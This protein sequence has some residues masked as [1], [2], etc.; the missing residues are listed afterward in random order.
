[1]LSKRLDDH[2]GQ[3]ARRQFLGTAA[4]VGAA[5]AGVSALDPAEALGF[6][7]KELEEKLHEVGTVNGLGVGSGALTEFSKQ[8]EKA[9]GEAAG[10]T[11]IGFGVLTKQLK[12]TAKGFTMGNTGVGTEA[13]HANESGVHNTAIGNSALRAVTG[14]GTT[15]EEEQAGVEET[16]TGYAGGF[17][18]AVGIGCMESLK[19][20]YHNTGMG[21]NCMG[22]LTGSNNTAFGANT[23][24][25][26][27]FAAKDTAI[28]I[29]AMEHAW[30]AQNGTAGGNNALESSRGGS[31]NTAWG[32]EALRYL[33][34]GNNNT[35][36]GGGAM[37][38]VAGV[39][40]AMK[41]GTTFNS[42]TPT[43]VEVE[44]ESITYEGK[45]LTLPTG[46]FEAYLTQANGNSVRIKVTKRTGKIL[47]GVTVTQGEDIVL[48]SGVFK[49]EETLVWE[50]RTVC[51]ENTVIGSDALAALESG[52]RN[53]AVGRYSLVNQ[54]TG[55]GNTA[56]GHASGFSNETAGGNTIVG[57][58]G[59]FANKSGGN[60]TCI[61]NEAGKDNEGSENIFLGAQAGLKE[62]GSKKLYIASSETTEPLI[63]GEFPNGELAFNTSKIALYKGVTPVTRHATIAE[64]TPSSATAKEAAERINEIVKAIKAIGII[65]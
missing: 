65:S 39:G 45:L 4:L 8:T 22:L 13:L 23:L 53:V 10:N 60:N 35:A 9:Q 56:V 16:G 61:G 20:G 46:T 38:G 44:S 14:V 18:T 43:N 24:E 28:G 6:A 50:I 58:E 12:V 11:A 21:T 37:R 32:S 27:T 57:Y 31:Y 1:M 47:E 48:G 30:T 15:K 2:D 33:Q 63:L 62:K 5:A 26:A 42:A 36:V 59:L 51:T 49:G 54:K 7:L 3:V 41:S 25:R 34:S 52:I 29:S 19:L 64:L 55:N 40:V 17:N